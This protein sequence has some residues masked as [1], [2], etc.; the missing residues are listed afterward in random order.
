M[1]LGAGYRGCAEL[2]KQPVIDNSGARYMRLVGGEKP[3]AQGFCRGDLF[4]RW[5]RWRTGRGLRYRCWWGCQ[6]GGDHAGGNRNPVPF[7]VHALNVGVVVLPLCAIGRLL[8]T[9]G[10]GNAAEDQSGAGADTGALLAADGC[11]CCSANHCSDRCAA[12]SGL[13]CALLGRAT[14]CLL[15]RILTADGFIHAEIIEA[16]ATAR[17]HHD[18]RAGGRADAAGDCEAGKQAGGEFFVH[19]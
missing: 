14:A 11:T 12:D 10:A 19:E 6:A 5:W 3:V 17:Q 15:Q 4:R 9:V 1:P 7:G 18:R 16:A 13:L 2:R 8:G